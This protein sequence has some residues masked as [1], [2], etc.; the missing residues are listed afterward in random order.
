V[1]VARVDNQFS[2]CNSDIALH[3]LRTSLTNHTIH[4]FV[5]Y[6]VRKLFTVC[7]C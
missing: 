4:A 1:A 6:L 2:D 3:K 7:V 5:T